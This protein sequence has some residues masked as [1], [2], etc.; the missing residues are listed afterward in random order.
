MKKYKIEFVISDKFVVDVLAKDEQEATEKAK[1]KWNK[2]EASG[3]EH[4]YQS[5]DPEMRVDT[6][7]DVSETDDP[8]NP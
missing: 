5:G 8:F 3:T 1:E 2:I 7:Y 4:Y 6:I